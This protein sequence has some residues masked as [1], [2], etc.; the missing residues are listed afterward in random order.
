[1]PGAPGRFVRT[2][3]HVRVD[4]QAG[5]TATIKGVAVTAPVDLKHD[6]MKDGPDE[7]QVGGVALWVHL[8]ATPPTWTSSGPSFIS[9]CLR[10][11]GAVTATPLIVAVIPA[12]GSTRTWSPVR[13]NRPGAPG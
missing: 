3:D 5:I 13:T 4:P 1:A 9:S 11:T 6:E 7:V 2:G 12:C 10:S 8:S